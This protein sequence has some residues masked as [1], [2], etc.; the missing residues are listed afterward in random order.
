M[1]G[2]NPEGRDSQD[3]DIEPLLRPP[4]PSSRIHAYSRRNNGLKCLL[5]FQFLTITG[6]ALFASYYGFLVFPQSTTPAQQVLDH[7]VVKFGNDGIFQSPPSDEVDKTWV[8]FRRIQDSEKPAARL[9]N[10]TYPTSGELSDYVVQLEVFH[11]LHCLSL[12]CAS[13]ISPLVWRWNPA[14]K[15]A[16]IRFDIVHSCCNF[17][18]IADWAKERHIETEP[19]LPN[20]TED[21]IVIPDF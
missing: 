13:D 9:P 16:E 8:D 17:N 12:M 7:E 20:E 5:A 6:L 1:P 18:R 19:D 14:A 21:D 11:Q 2:N 4:R 3:L 15:R 10:K